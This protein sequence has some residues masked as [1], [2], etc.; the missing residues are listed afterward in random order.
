[1]GS[2]KLDK[3]I[4]LAVTVFELSVIKKCLTSC[5]DEL[6]WKNTML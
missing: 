1:M 6:E 4:P 5:L 2:K 3:T